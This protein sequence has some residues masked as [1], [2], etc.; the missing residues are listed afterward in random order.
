MLEIGQVVVVSATVKEHKEFGGIRETHLTRVKPYLTPEQKKALKNAK[1]A[2]KLK[3]EAAEK[4]VEE[5]WEVYK[6]D[7]NR[8]MYDTAQTRARLA[9][10]EWQ[11]L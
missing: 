3:Y 6:R 2:A 1:K 4:A 10:K 8:D 5:A 7:G 9:Y 11:A